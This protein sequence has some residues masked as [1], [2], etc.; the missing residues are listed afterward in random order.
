MLTYY[1][2]VAGVKVYGIDPV[3]E[4]DVSDLEQ[5]LMRPLPGL[6]VLAPGRFNVES[7]GVVWRT[8]W[9]W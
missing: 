1:A 9:G 3:R 2:Q 6:S 8:S 7:S 4:P 5:H